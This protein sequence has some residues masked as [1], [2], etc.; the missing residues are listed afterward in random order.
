MNPY[1]S[2]TDQLARYWTSGHGKRLKADGDERVAVCIDCHGAHEILSGGEPESRTNP[3]NVP[4][5]CGTCHGDAGLMAEYD[6]PVEVVEE[7]RQSIHG[8]LLIEQ[9]DTGA[10]TCATCHGNHSAMPPGFASVGAVCGQCHQHATEA[11]STSIHASQPEFRGC[12]QC[13]GGG[14]GRHSHLVERITKGPAAMIQR[15]TLLLASEPEPSPE[16]VTEM[17]H[18]DPKQILER[19]LPT[20]LDCHEDLED[21]ESLP[22]LFELLDDIAQA[23]QHYVHTGN[24]LNRVGR[25]VLLVDSQLFKFEDAKTHLIE[26]AALQHTLNNSQV[27]EK[28]AQLNAICAE[29]NS[30]LDALEEG[31]RWRYSALIPIWAFALFFGSVLYIKYKLLKRAYVKPLPRGAQ[32]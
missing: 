19:A 27:D 21:D 8:R 31:L 10:P 16:R 26:L 18:P 6:L 11:F 1:G 17:I 12:V 30:E 14:E 22:R 2:R 23:E 5:T 20:C 24:R 25:G 3:L 13:H 28:V 15:Y 9:H 4:D 32:R 29:V 7:Y